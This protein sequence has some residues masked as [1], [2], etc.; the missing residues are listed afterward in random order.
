M[1]KYKDWDEFS[2]KGWELATSDP[3]KT[4]WLLK[5]NSGRGLFKVK[6]TSG[7]KTYTYTISNFEAEFNKV[8]QFSLTMTRLL[9]HS[10][11]SKKTKKKQ[12]SRQ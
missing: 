8:K 12:R 9:T 5:W 1:V 7:S 4:R 2:I 10:E 11:E 6:V 3:S